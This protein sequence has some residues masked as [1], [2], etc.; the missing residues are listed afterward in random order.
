MADELATKCSSLSLEDKE[1]DLVDLGGEEKSETPNNLAVFL[2]GKL[3][4]H[5]PYNVEAF[6]RT[7]TKVW[8]PLHNLVI[9][10]IGHN[11]YAFQF[12]HWKDRENVLKGRPWC[13][14]N[15]LLMLQE[16]SGD[17]QPKGVTL[18]H[19]PFWIRVCNL[20][21]NCRTN[22]DLKILTANLGE[23]LELEDDFLGLN[24]YRRVC[25]IIDVQK[26]LRRYQWM[27]DKSGNKVKIEFKYERLPYFC[28]ACGIMGHSEKYCVAIPKE[29]KSN[30]LGW[31][32][33]LKVS[34]RRG[35]AK[36]TEEVA[37]IAAARK[38]L[39]VTKGEE[40]VSNGVTPKP[41]SLKEGQMGVF[42]TKRGCR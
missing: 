6:K 9:R 4:T 36:E 8:E 27:K 3:L 40:E 17:E 23:M 39:F 5:R 20:P 19:L 7:M 35:F 14:E 11:L 29:G 26:P 31:G 16:G 2:V 18:T 38:L 37:P 24:R 28:F 1:N 15:N 30:K 25:I 42:W 34:P 32:M 10:V 33:F 41:I 22:D 13:W 12:F 21:F